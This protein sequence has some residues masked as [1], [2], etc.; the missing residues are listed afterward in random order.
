MTS[1][2]RIGHGLPAVAL[3]LLVVALGACGSTEDASTT[4]TTVDPA[5]GGSP[6]T[7]PQVSGVLIELNIVDKAVEG[8]V[9]RHDVHLGETVKIVVTSDEADELHVHGYDLMLE[10]TPGQPAELTFEAAIPGVFEVE[11]EQSGLKVAEL[12]VA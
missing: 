8:G 7:T 12:Q 2:A 6:D 11:L 1:D 4:T 3:I 10:L 5:I 9:A